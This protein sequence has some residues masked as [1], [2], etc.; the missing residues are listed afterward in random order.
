MTN[1]TFFIDAFPYLDIRMFY[2]LLHVFLHVVT[3]IIC[4]VRVYYL[5]V[6]YYVTGHVGVTGRQMQ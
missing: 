6:N 2:I 3:C 1:V 4:S 5:W